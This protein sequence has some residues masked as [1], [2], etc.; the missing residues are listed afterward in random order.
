MA[1]TL[2]IR[3]VPRRSRRNL[4][5]AHAGTAS[6]RHLHR[7]L[8][9]GR[10]QCLRRKTNGDL[11]PHR[12]R[13]CQQPARPGQL[14]AAGGIAGR[15]ATRPLPHDTKVRERRATESGRPGRHYRLSPHRR[16]VHELLST[17][18]RSTHHWYSAPGTGTCT[19]ST[20]KTPRTAAAGR[21]ENHC[22]I[23]AASTAAKSHHRCSP[24]TV[25]WTRTGL[26]RAR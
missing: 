12:R 25:I 21:C 2:V 5:G 24:G 15:S 9:R 26:R 13:R 7:Q 20:T 3:Q 1:V 14:A 23:P 4:A 18:D 16:S 19:S 17:R 10:R 22:P 6:R 11:H 8:P